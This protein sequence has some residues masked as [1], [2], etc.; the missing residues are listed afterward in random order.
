MLQGV[1]RPGAGPCSGLHPVRMHAVATGHPKSP[2]WGEATTAL[3][4][5][6]CWVVACEETAGNSS[7]TDASIRIPILL[8]PESRPFG[9]VYRPDATPLFIR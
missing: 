3:G 9:I 2:A 7:Q 1:F 4:E 5:T 8:L 6:S